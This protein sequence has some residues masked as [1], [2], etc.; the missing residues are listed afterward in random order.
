MEGAWASWWRTTNCARRCA[1]KGLGGGPP[2]P[3]GDHRRFDLRGLHPSH[4]GANYSATAKAFSLMEL[5]NG[6]GICGIDQAGIDRV[7][8]IQ[9]AP[10][11]A[12]QKSRAEF[13]ARLADMTRQH[14]RARQEIR[15]RT[16]SPR[17]VRRV[18]SAVPEVRRRGPP[19][20]TS[21]SSASMKSA[22]S[23]SGKP[24]CSRMFEMER[25]ESSSR[26]NKSGR[27]RKFPQQKGISIHRRAEADA[28][29]KI[30]FDFWQRAE[31]R[32]WRGRCAGGFHPARSR[33]QMSQVRRAGCSTPG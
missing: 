13:M 3:R 26:K 21:N 2:H 25:V 33:W 7:I 23:R 1:E 10:D 12:P 27:C 32:K 29:F 17:D 16:R 6:L 15:G 4:T 28:E 14:C 30:E 18:E 20:N 31:K 5:L 9:A 19:K 22:T 8:G 24:L 11:P